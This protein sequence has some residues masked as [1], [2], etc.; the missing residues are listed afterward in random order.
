MPADQAQGILTYL[1]TNPDAAKAAWTQAQA[2]MQS[3]GLANAFI[4]MSV[5]SRQ[6][7]VGLDATV[8]AHT[9][10]AVMPGEG[11]AAAAKHHPRIFEG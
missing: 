11:A 5:S 1:K 2:I 4:N 8:Q 6:L 10:V 7:R 9:A 3:P